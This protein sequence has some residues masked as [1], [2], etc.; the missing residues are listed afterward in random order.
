MRGQTRDQKEPVASG[1]REQLACSPE[2]DRRRVIGTQ[3]HSRHGARSEV[4]GNNGLLQRIDVLQDAVQF[5]H[6]LW[7]ARVVDCEARELRADD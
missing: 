4:G 1:R 3:R 2:R 7:Q 5:R 6:E